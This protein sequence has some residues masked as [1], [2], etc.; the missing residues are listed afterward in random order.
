MFY[1]ELIK[2]VKTAKTSAERERALLLLGE[3]CEEN[4]TS[5]NG[6]C[7]DVPELNGSLYP[8]YK[9]FSDEQYDLVGYEL[10]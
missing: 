10:R 3:W 6:E 8:V 1:S 5:W 2:N 9:K 7:F 4:N